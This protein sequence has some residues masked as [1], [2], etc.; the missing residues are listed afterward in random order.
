M[1]VSSHTPGP[2]A[3]RI[4]FVGIGNVLKKDDG[5]GV[6]ISEKIRETKHTGTLTAEVSIENYIGKIN[7]LNPD[8]LVLIDC[9]NFNQRPGTWKL[10]PV[11]RIRAHALHT[12]NISLKQV[13][14]LFRMPVWVLGIQPRTTSFGESLSP[15]VWRTADRIIDE[16]NS[17]DSSIFPVRNRPA[18]TPG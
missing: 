2:S 1:P 18:R 14:E 4:L 17:P 11:D 15:E 13:S 3:K 8:F 16:L 7:R 9:M 6:Y 12:H 10:L 5:V